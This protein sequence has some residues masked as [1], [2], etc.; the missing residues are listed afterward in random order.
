MYM[1]KLFYSA[2]LVLTDGNFIEVRILGKVS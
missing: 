1:T 2:S